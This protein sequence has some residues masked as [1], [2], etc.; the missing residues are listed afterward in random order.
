MIDS[1]LIN[2]IN[3]FPLF[4]ELNEELFSIDPADVYPQN[5]KI[6][7]LSSQVEFLNLD[8]HT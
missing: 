3:D 5:S 4:P 6:V 2:D 8:V 1:N 7:S